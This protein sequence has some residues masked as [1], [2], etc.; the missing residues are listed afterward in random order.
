MPFSEAEQSKLR[1]CLTAIEERFDGQSVRSVVLAGNP[2]D[3][4]S[5]LELI[6]TQRRPGQTRVRPSRNLDG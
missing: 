2:R 3:P 5:W 4:I 6:L 1:P